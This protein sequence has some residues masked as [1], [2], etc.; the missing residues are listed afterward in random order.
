MLKFKVDLSPL[1]DNC[2]ACGSGLGDDDSDVDRYLLYRNNATT[3]FDTGSLPLCYRCWNNAGMCDTCMIP[4][5]LACYNP[6]GDLVLRN[7]TLVEKSDQEHRCVNCIQFKPYKNE[8]TCAN[9]DCY[10]IWN[11]LIKAPPVILMCGGSVKVCPICKSKGFSVYNG[12]GDGKFY[13][14]QNGN[15]IANYDLKTAYGLTEA[16][17]DLREVF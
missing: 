15:E 2:P 17:L 5:N 11:E 1:K 16:D 4:T 8:R 12:K 3:L 7:T 6:A 9:K 10:N 14:S 13:L